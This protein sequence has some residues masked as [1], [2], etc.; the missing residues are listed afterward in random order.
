MTLARTA[1]GRDD[2]RARQAIRPSSRTTSVVRRAGRPTACGPNGRSDAWH[3][4]AY[5]GP[6]RRAHA[7]ALPADVRFGVGA[8]FQ[9]VAGLTVERRA[10]LLQRL[11]ADAF[12]FARFEQRDVLLGDA[13]A[14]GQLFRPHLAAGE[15]HVEID[16]DRHCRVLHEARILVGKTRCFPHHG[17]DREQRAAD[18]Q[19][20]VVVQGKG[21]RKHARARLAGHGDGERQARRRQRT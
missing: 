5:G 10:D 13:D 1:I 19:R 12:D 16:D 15:H 14:F 11:E 21:D 3:K 4:R 8:I 9:D 17:R 7:R 18:D 6:S 20:V 2:G